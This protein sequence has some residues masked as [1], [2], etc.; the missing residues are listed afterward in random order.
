MKR[1]NLI[2]ER[3]KRNLTRKQVSE[4]TGIKTATL[5]RYENGT[6]VKISDKIADKLALFYGFEKIKD[7]EELFKLEEYI[8][9]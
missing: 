4:K 3:L 5:R 9:E 2:Y 1:Y 7:K 8:D 6:I